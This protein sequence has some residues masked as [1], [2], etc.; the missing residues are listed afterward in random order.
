MIATTTPIRRIR[1]EPLSARAE[2][3]IVARA[4]MGIMTLTLMYLITNSATFRDPGAADAANRNLL[5]FQ[6]LVRDRPPADQRMFRELQEGL[7]EAETRRGSSGA[8]PAVA[9]LAGEGIPPF[10]PDPTV[11]GT[12]YDWSLTQDG[13]IVNYLGTPRQSTSPAWLVVIREPEP[14]VPPDQTFEDE[15]HHRLITGAMLHVS[16]W[17]RA[18]TRLATRMTRSPQTEGWTQ[19][20]AVPPS[21]VRHPPR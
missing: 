8:W 10:A 14:G 19:L 4:A 16:T 12:Q 7:L 20:Y 5:P 15:E 17:T 11:K 21:A 9:V 13:P 1:I 3:Q 2:L 18:D 6:V